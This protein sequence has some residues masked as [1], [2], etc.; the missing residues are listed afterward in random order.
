VK[1]FTTNKKASSAN[2][3]LSLVSPS[4]HG[5]Y[6]MLILTRPALRDRLMRHHH[7]YFATSEFSVNYR[8]NF[9]FHWPFGFDETHK[10]SPSTNTYRISP[11]FERYCSD[12]KSWTLNKEFF[13]KFPEYIGDIPV[14]EVGPEMPLTDPPE[15]GI[16]SQNIECNANFEDECMMALFDEIPPT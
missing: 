9:K 13:K 5:V 10:Y 11:L 14:H 15:V 6:L 1:V 12:E 4:K 16:T 7:Y 3:L 8:Q 2:R